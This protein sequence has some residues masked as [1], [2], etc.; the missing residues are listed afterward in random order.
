MLAAQ[1]IWEVAQ[2]KLRGKLL[3]I[4]GHP[5]IGLSSEGDIVNINK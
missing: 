3:G 1:S 5:L 2:V 4:I